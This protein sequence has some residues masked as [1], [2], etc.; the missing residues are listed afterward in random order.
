MLATGGKILGFIRLT[1][2]ITEIIQAREGLL[3]AERFATLGQM[4][5]GVAHD[6]G[7]PLSIISGYS[8]YL[9]MRTLPESLGH[10]ELTIILNQTRRIADFIKQLL[11]LARPAQARVDAIGLRGFLGET[12]E[13]VG[14]HFKKADV[15]AR[16][17]PGAVSPLV[18]VDAPRLRQAIFNLLM[19]A[20][21]KVGPG[22]EVAIAIEQPASNGWAVIIISGKRSGGAVYDLP[23]SF[24]KL[25]DFESSGYVPDL[26]L[27]LTKEIL[28]EL[29]V[30]VERGDTAGSIAIRV[31]TGG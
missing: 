19:N 23:S 31:P 27:T 21:Q 13:L 12:V 7:T 4:I 6:V 5:S 11:E 25:L 20:S 18:Y 16:I 10:K 17:E 26:G 24:S 3:R 30:M 22:G 28:R 29:G 14:H 2:D 1:N 9:L 8:E 15:K